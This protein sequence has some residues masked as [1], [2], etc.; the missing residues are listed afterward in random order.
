ME[1]I[2]SSNS[3]TLLDAHNS[4]KLILRENSVVKEV[5]YDDTVKKAVGVIVIDAITKEEITFYAK[6]I[7][8][9]ASAIATASIFVEF[10][11]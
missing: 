8:L 6:I 5:I 7:F 9:N 11:F 10:C 2:F 3:S 1:V 4:G